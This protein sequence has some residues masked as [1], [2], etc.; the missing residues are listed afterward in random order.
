MTNSSENNLF[1]EEKSK[2]SNSL[3]IFFLLFSIIPLLSVAIMLYAEIGISIIIFEAFI[4][5]VILITFQSTLKLKIDAEG[6]THSY[7]PFVSKKLLKW[8]EIENIQVIQFSS[9]F[10]IGY[11]VKYDLIHGKKR[12]TTGLLCVSILLKNNTKYLITLIDEDLFRKS[13]EAFS[14]KTFEIKKVKK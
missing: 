5:V 12:T 10:Q 4:I 1:Y 8:E 2:I 3:F 7:P 13:V 11:G 6:I 14:E 9:F